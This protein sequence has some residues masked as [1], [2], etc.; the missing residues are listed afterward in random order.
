VS[1]RHCG[2]ELQ[3]IHAAEFDAEKEPV[4]DGED[5]AI[6][7]VSKHPPAQAIINAAKD[8]DYELVAGAC[9]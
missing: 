3:I 4:P 1:A 2:A 8:Y 7:W 5:T 9:S 6:R